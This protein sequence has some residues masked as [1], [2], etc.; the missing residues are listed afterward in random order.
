MPC[1]GFPKIQIKDCEKRFLWKVQAHWEES[2]WSDAMK[3]ATS[4][5]SEP[6]VLMGDKLNL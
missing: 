4:D 2:R 3:K 5:V 1:F 6:A